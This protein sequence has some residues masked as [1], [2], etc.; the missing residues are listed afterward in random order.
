M[1]GLMGKLYD[2]RRIILNL[3]KG[4]LNLFPGAVAGYSLRRLS[5]WKIQ[6]PS[7][8]VTPL[9]A[10][11]LR[12]V[13]VGYTG[14][15]VRVRRSSDNAELDFN[16]TEITDGTLTTWTGSGDGFVTKIYDQSSG[17]NDMVQATASL[18]GIIVDAGVLNT[19]GGK[20]IIHRSASNDGGYLSTFQPN[21]GASVKGMFYV[22]DNN[23]K[24]SMIFG[25][26]TGVNDYGFIAVSG[27]TETLIDNNPTVTASIINGASNTP[28]NRGVAYTATDLQFLMY[29][30]IQFNFGDN[31]LG[32]GY[33]QSSPAGFG[34][35]SFQ[36]LIICDTDG[37]G[38]EMEFNINAYYDIYEQWDGESVA[39]VRRSSD[40]AELDFTEQDITNS[41]M[42]NWVNTD[43]VQFQS[44]FIAASNQF[45]FNSG[46]TATVGESIA[47]QDN[48]YKGVLTG[49]AGVK[50]TGA[51]NFLDADSKSFDITYDIYIPSTNSVLDQIRFSGLFPGA[52]FTPTQDTWVTITDSGT[53]SN[54]DLRF[55]PAHN[56]DADMDADGDVF[57]LKNITLTQT[58]SDGFVTT[59]YDQSGNGNDAKQTIA[60][61]QPKLVTAGVLNTENGKPLIVPDDE[62]VGF[63]IPS[64]RGNSDFWT[65]N[66]LKAPTTSA[67][68][69]NGDSTD[70][71]LLACISGNTSTT[72]SSN[73][74]TPVYYEDGS[75]ATYANRGAVF[76][77]LSD[78][79]LMTVKADTSSWNYL[80]IGYS[81]SGLGMYSMQEMIIYNADKTSD[82]AG[83]ESNINNHY[84]IY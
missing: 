51:S 48:C 57:Y 60:S 31:V 59:L 77:A 29:R 62:T 15:V 53:S 2:R 54:D 76:T 42:L 16:P 83:I 34:M 13:V 23:G 68:L 12:Y 67:M 56:D 44:N 72:L 10:L 64:Y 75:V 35:F 63:D 71:Y 1:L 3:F 41:T 43:V 7:E 50:G 17:D 80:E 5:K 37:K 27:S 73:A 11:S 58:T 19:E 52:F 81:S 82:R 74:G 66:V 69:L 36:E 33:R 32:L 22:G 14:A 65:F 21:D 20:P 78:Q 18:Q 40:N 25:S 26:N 8:I 6:L 84:S 38:G 24:T 30:E 28:A 47:G 49:G 39:K 4:I 9:L 61:A 45:N 46:I 70:E 79:S 55:Y